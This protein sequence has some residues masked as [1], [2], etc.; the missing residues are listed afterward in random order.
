[1]KQI[2][3]MMQK[4]II[5]KKQMHI[6]AFVN[7]ATLNPVPTIKTFL[8]SKHSLPLFNKCCKYR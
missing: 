4:I 3:I 2:K 6:L 1:M 5:G 8:Q 7:K